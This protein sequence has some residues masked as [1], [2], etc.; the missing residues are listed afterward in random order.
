M[1]ALNS[2]RVRGNCWTGSSGQTGNT[3]GIVI[4]GGCDAF[5][6]VVFWVFC[7]PKMLRFINVVHLDGFISAH[8]N[9]MMIRSWSPAFVRNV[10]HCSMGFFFTRIVLGY[11]FSINTV[12]LTVKRLT[13][14]YDIWIILLGDFT[15]LI[16]DFL[17][18]FVWRNTFW[19]CYF[20]FLCSFMFAPLLQFIIYYL[21]VYKEEGKFI[22]K[23]SITIKNFIILRTKN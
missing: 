4:T 3:F 11:R 10:S 13:S 9:S 8:W 23:F 5:S 17:L 21:K 19:W 12:L 22:Y 14:I 18:S 7:Q 15:W 6:R 1:L 2:I 20:H 16:K